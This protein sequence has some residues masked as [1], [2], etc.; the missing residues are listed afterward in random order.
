MNSFE[1]LGLSRGLVETIE[2][3]G[4]KNPTPIQEQA[5]PVL[6]TGD[7]DFVG[8]AQ[9]GTGKTAAF[10]LPLIELVNEKIKTTQA[11]VLAPTRELCMQITE[12]LTTYCKGYKPLQIVAVYGGASISEQIRQV[13]K[14]AQIIVATPG[15]LIDLA[16]RGAVELSVIN[17]VVLDEADE[18]LNMG[19]KDDLDKILS[20]TP[21]EKQ[22]WLFSATMPK[23]VRDIANNYMYN[24][25]EITVG[26]KN[27]GNANIEH[28]YAIV[29]DKDKYAA[30]KRLLDFHSD[31]FG[32]V[33]CRTK[34]DT[35]EVAD[36]LMRDGY[37][38]DALHGDMTQPMRDRVMN[39]FRNRE[40]NVLVATDVAAR[41][42]DVNNI[43]HVLHLN[44]P[45]DIEYYTHRS[46]R[47]ARAGKQGIS[48][49]LISSRDVKKISMIE[50][51]AKVKFEQIKVPNGP[52]ICQKQLMRIVDKV[53]DVE[54][55]DFELDTFM[56]KVYHAL[57]DLTK[58]EI[59]KRFAAIEFNRFLEYYRNAP[60]LNPT[61]R[62]S[63]KR[64]ERE[65][66]GAGVRG[67]SNGA[68][69][70]RMFINLG[71]MDGLDKGRMLGA[72]C[73]IA[74]VSK[75][76]VGRID[77]LNSYS[78]FELDKSFAQQAV[79]R[80]A[81][82]EYKGRVV[83]IDVAGDRPEKAP[84]AKPHRKGKGGDK[85]APKGRKKRGELV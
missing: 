8:L 28:Q 41:G 85:P 80:A 67:A 10:G 51:M 12:G 34:M 46:G 22:T 82:F 75:K 20:F 63:S 59:I 15:R 32:L 44:L 69:F 60:D 77:I 19:F 25:H 62:G 61:E 73:E 4:F 27:A 78:F 1:S 26:E 53:H 66:E 2:A 70:E 55:N 65:R 38:A 64:G 11:L 39:K 17:Y 50:R 57:K 48:I 54:V 6:L 36:Q 81:D 16:S 23:M 21:D 72:I 33:F 45:D 29:R 74:D 84:A 76:A 31:I 35:Q 5:I 18:M 40:L 71:K 37:N 52:E 30:L 83:R 9:T 43:T 68:G 56:P 42:I 14:G 79:K 24:P 47:T 3:F 7:R 13:R 49:A 58:E